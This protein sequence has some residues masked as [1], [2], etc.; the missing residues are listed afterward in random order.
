MNSIKVY[1]YTRLF[2]LGLLIL[3]LCNCSRQI[4]ILRVS[5]ENVF[6]NGKHAEDMIDIKDNDIVT[7]GAESSAKIEFKEGG[8]FQLDENTDPV[9][10]LERF[11][12]GI[13]IVIT[14]I[15]GQAY[16]ESG[17]WCEKINTT[18]TAATIRSRVNIIVTSV[19]TEITVIQGNVRIDSFL[20]NKVRQTINRSQSATISSKDGV[21]P[22]KDLSAAELDLKIAWLKKYKFSTTE[23]KSSKKRIKR[24]IRPRRRNR[25]DD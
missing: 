2:F 6:I 10:I 21:L 14:M 15:K 12:S 25:R 19:E 4:G 9:F 1:K 7:T 17:K 13:C 24:P 16:T 20:G 3:I 18:N 22:N 11:Q 23:K 8:F 5:G